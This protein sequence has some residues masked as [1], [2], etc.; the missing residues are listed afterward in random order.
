MRACVCSKGGGDLGSVAAAG[1]QCSPRGDLGSAAAAGPLLLTLRLGRL[2]RECVCVCVRVCAPWAYPSHVKD[3]GS[4]NNY[5]LRSWANPSHVKHWGGKKIAVSHRHQ[6]LVGK[7]L[8]GSDESL[9]IKQVAGDETADERRLSLGLRS[10][11]RPL[12]CAAKVD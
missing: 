7:G 9:P 10:C 3:R 6:Q 8:C 1:P 2:E 12:L 11:C 4:E 5:L